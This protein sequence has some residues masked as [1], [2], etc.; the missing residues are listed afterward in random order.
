MDWIDFTRITYEQMK[1][2]GFTL[3]L[4][5]G[6]SNSSKYYK[7]KQLDLIELER[8]HPLKQ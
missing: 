4:K 5:D 6:V 3:T 1:S 8:G 7:K 2:S